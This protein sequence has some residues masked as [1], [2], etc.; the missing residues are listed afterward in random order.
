[1]KEPLAATAGAPVTPAPVLP[2]DASRDLWVDHAKGLGIVLVVYGHVAR[3]LFNAQVPM[4]EATYRAVDAALYS[5]HMP[6]FFFLAGLFFVDSLQKR[7][8]GGFVLNKVDTIVYPYVL[9]SI[10]QG[11]IEV[12]M[13]QWTN[14][15]VG[16]R[17]VLSLLW[18]PRAHFWFLYALFLIC[19]LGALV[20][21]VVSRR[22]AGWVALAGVGLYLA[23]PYLPDVP[24]LGFVTTFFVYVAAGVWFRDLQASVARHARWG[25]WAL[26]AACLAAQA[27]LYTESAAGRDVGEALRLGI[28]A[29]S[30]AFVVLLCQGLAPGRPGWLARLGQASMVIYLAHVLAGSGARIVLAKLFHTQHLGLHLVVGCAAGIGV[31]LV[32]LSLARRSR[33]VAALFENPV[34]LE[35]RLRRQPHPA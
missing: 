15:Q 7:G 2:H 16:L 18:A 30:I 20:Y 6:L 5:F 17:D 31:S 3:G 22:H 28:A 35:Q 1:M 21:S 23:R 24:N 32:L 10:L 13:G 4:D 27:F 34:P 26:G 8:A 11:L 29:V 25:V 14:G 12:V 9:W 19:L 33:L